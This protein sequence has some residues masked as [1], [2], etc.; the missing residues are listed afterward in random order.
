MA[1]RNGHVGDQKESVVALCRNNSIDENV[2]HAIVTPFWCLS[3]FGPMVLI[4]D[5][6][7]VFK[8]P[9]AKRE[10]GWVCVDIEDRERSGLVTLN[11]ATWTTTRHVFFV[12][13]QCG[14]HDVTYQRPTS[15]RTSHGS[16]S[17]AAKAPVQFS[18][19]ET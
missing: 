17:V 5:R 7:E 2:R 12:G 4:W 19:R 13:L 8:G 11:D 10:G 3:R 18:P 6:V 16:Q 14:S 15:P 1:W 9:V